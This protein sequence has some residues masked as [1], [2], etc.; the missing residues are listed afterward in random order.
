[1]KK[2]LS[3]LL[4][5]LMVASLCS[6]MVFAEA[7]PN[8]VIS[9]QNAQGFA[10][11][12]VSVT[13]RIDDTFEVSAANLKIKYD[14]KLELI[15]VENG[16]FFINSTPS[17]IYKQDTKGVNGEYNYIGI[18]N[19]DSASSASGELVKLNFKLP[20]DAKTGDTYSVKVER[21]D[22]ILTTGIDSL[23]S[24]VVADGQITAVDSTACASHT[25]GEEVVL[26]TSSILS[27]GYKYKQC[28]VCSYTETTYVPAI[29]INVFEYLGTSMNYTGKPSGIAPM[30]NVDMD[31]L[32]KIK[33]SNKNYKVYAGIEIYKN[34]LYYDEEVF[35]GEGATYSLTNNVLFV[36]L[37]DVSAYDK[38]T[39]KAY[40]KITDDKTGNE[41]VAYTVAT[42]RESEEISICD[43]VKCLNL[44]DY[45][46]ENRVY[47]QNILDGFAD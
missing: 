17:A 45:S 27:T 43:V 12:T 7:T 28:T 5:V 34:G 14:T 18:N 2:I 4:A 36:K 29:E 22:S 39:F 46:K 41:R 31:A 9:V 8:T 26:G 23:K 21:K 35:F 1:M 15:S 6:T 10:S 47:L 40:V 44:K 13:V 3:L 16:G 11:Q 33:E 24:F 30:Y 37:T 38:F 32:N 19:G 25:F 42:V 20:S